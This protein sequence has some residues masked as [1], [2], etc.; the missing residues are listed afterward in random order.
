MINKL[1]YIN[2]IYNKVNL[3]GILIEFGVDFLDFLA[4]II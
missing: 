3:G 2:F 4:K 1:L